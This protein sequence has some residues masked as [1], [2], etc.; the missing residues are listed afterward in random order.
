MP[1]KVKKVLNFGWYMSLMSLAS[2]ISLL[3]GFFVAG[4]LDVSS[5]GRYA[6]LVATGMFFSSLL[7]FGEIEKT[8]KFFPRLWLSGHHFEVLKATDKSVKVLFS[9][10]ALIGYLLLGCFFL[11]VMVE[12]AKSGLL[13]VVVALNAA[14]ASIYASAIRATGNTNILARNTFIRSLIVLLLASF[15]ATYYSWYG[16][17]LGEAI[18]FQL[19]A[20]VTRYSLSKQT[21][22]IMNDLP[23]L[24]SDEPIMTGK[25]G[26]YWLF[27]A[28][29]CVAVP[30][31][32]DRAFIS[33]VYDH[34]TV[35]TLGFLM[36]FVTGAST[37]TGIITQKVGPQLVKMQ[38][39][40]EQLIN[41][42][43]YSVRWLLLIWVTLALGLVVV[44]LL[45]V[46]G[47]ARIYYDKFHLNMS[48]LITTS[49]LCMLQISVILDYLI[50]SRNVEKGV[51]LSAF[52]Y[53]CVICFG[54][55]NVWHFKL[56]L[57]EFIWML[58][59]CKLIHL[60]MQA[61]VIAKLLHSE[62]R[63]WSY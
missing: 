33:S 2:A 12:G 18:G 4:L 36:L 63:S 60:F 50:I 41:Q 44:D 37:L 1:T 40:D 61:L 27:V 29:L 35:G 38:H 49:V 46:F 13:V 31:F 7:S 32:L 3:R 56:S 14:I 62:S 24:K 30:T 47:P 5:F 23:Q 48:L 58:V 17:I 55:Y 10:V 25:E 57:V 51:F 21:K 9:R 16:A 8:I 28:T 6:T 22:R 52:I 15:G 39:T 26:K 20:L 45:M 42:L 43:R 19:G 11:G 59:V 54:A 53:L 34:L